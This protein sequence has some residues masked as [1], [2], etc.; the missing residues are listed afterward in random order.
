MPSIS[1]AIMVRDDAV[2]LRRAIQSAKNAVEEVVILDTGSKDDT[3]AV[4][5]Q[6]GARVHEIAWPNNFSQALNCLLEHVKTD[7]TLRLD[8]D[9]WFEI[10]PKPAISECIVDEGAHSFRLVRRDLQ[11]HGDYEEIALIRLWR[12]SPQLRYSGVVHENIP[13]AAFAKAWP[14]KDERTAPLWFWHDGYGQGHLDKIRRN[15]PLME[16]ELAKNPVQ[17]YYE[18]MLAKGY[19]DVGD[20]KWLP[21]MM[22]IAERSLGEKQP[23]TPVLSVIFVDVLNSITGEDLHR[24]RTDQILLRALHWFPHTPQVLVAA[25]NLELRRGRK[26]RALEILLV[27]EQMATTGEY[28][29][30]MPVNPGLFGK[31]FWKHLDHLADQLGR[32]DVC[33]RCDPHL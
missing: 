29:R 26:D 18:A 16:Q 5:R 33:K 8:S 17:P 19:K 12:T 20:D 15:I 32:W 9:E 6:E 28:D 23:A 7:W 2:R 25:S 24:A 22:R 4:A 27:L 31:Q 30:S 11:P 21:L 14:G 10:D 13:T 1:L 3:V